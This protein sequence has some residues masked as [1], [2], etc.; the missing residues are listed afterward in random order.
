MIRTSKLRN[1]NFTSSEIVALLA[2]G[3]RPMTEE[4]LAARPKKGKGSSVTQVPDLESLG[5]KALTYIEER[6]MERGLGRPL[7]NEANSRPTLWGKLVERR[8][9]DILPTDYQ[10]VSQE[11]I[12]HPEFDFWAGSPDANKFD[13]G[14][15][16]VD[17]KC[18]MTL[19]SFCK[20]VAPLYRGLSGMEAM[21]YVRLNHDDGEKYYFQLVSN[22]ILTESRF[23]ELI[24]YAPFEDELT[25][26]RQLVMYLED[27]DQRKYGWLVNADDNELPF[28]R[29][30]GKYN[31]LNV[32]RFE[33][34][35]EDKRLLESRVKLCGK[36]LETI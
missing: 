11:T 29:K 20:L 33:V 35:D 36:Y 9:F 25:H 23:A 26:I 21:E 15:T 4:E 8:V 28:I 7:D 18:P 34:P 17:I 32:I 5:D 6:N 1:G 27:E 3:K 19:K 2:M 24:V 22:A 13:H 31:N 14:R 30:G 12:V 10:L 16:V